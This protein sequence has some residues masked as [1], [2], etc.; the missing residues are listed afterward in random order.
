M[1]RNQGSK[2]ARNPKT[3]RRGELKKKAKEKSMQYA[4]QVGANEG[5]ALIP[6]R[7]PLCLERAVKIL[8]D[9]EDKIQ[10]GEHEVKKVFRDPNLVS[11]PEVH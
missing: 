3:V 5:K 4:E 6:G 10:K 1:M 7:Q 2:N 9:N 8:K 11:E